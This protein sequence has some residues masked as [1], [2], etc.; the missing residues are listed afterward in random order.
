MN[1]TDQPP[2]GIAAE[3]AAIFAAGMDH[4]PFGQWLGLEISR[5]EDDRVTMR[6]EM[7]QEFIGNSAINVL[8]GGII[9]AALDTVGGM[10]AL[11]GVLTRTAQR[12]EDP[13]SPWLSTIDM[14]TDYLRPG[15]GKEFT[16]AAFPL[17]VGRR[18]VVTR[19]ELHNESGDLIA[20]G[21]GTYSVP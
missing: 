9:S 5:I 18:S 4:V 6:F 19:M 7:R 1:R 16:A 15:S 2:D 17:R 10:A 8:H 12:S 21:T 3:V 13:P 11:L 14:R 20:V